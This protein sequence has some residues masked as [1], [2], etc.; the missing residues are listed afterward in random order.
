M[1]SDG[2]ELAAHVILGWNIGNSIEAIGGE[3]VWG[4]PPVTKDLIDLAK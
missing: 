1:S 3:T 2:T 4:N